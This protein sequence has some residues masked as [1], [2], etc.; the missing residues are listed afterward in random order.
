MGLHP[1]YPI[2]TD[3]LLLR[4]I[5]T[6]DISALH[7]YQS[8]PDNVRY[9]P[10]EPRSIDAVTELV[11]SGRLT[12]GVDEPPGTISLGVELRESGVLVADVILM[13]HSL[14][15]RTGEVG[16]ISNPS[17]AGNGYV[18]E[19]VRELLRLGFDGLGLH[20]IAARLDARNDASAAVARRLGMKQE[21]HLRENE[22]FKGEW[23]DEI[24]YAILE[25]EWRSAQASA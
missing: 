9:V 14:E 8:V 22:W 1:D 21:A 13:W 23:T 18:T 24:V 6:A 10:Y 16:Y 20:R 15:H 11:E 7:A 19:A 25:D 17:H 5:T 2:I 4:P 12:S 3:R